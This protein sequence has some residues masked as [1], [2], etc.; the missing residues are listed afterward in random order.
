MQV[1]NDAECHMVG[2]RNCGVLRSGEQSLTSA[3]L[4]FGK[5]V[6]N[7]RAHTKWLGGLRNTALAGLRHKHGCTFVVIA[8][9]R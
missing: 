3:G 6:C 5:P 1:S 9:R 4:Y 7:T 8:D 2:L